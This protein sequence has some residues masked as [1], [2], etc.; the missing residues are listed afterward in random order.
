MIDALRRRVQMMLARGVV[1]LADDSTQAQS[2]QIDLLA[3]ETHEG[4]ERFCDYGFSSV[5]LAGAEAIVAFVGGLRSHG[6]AIKVE[7]RRYRPRDL[8][9]GE[10]TLYDDQGQRV[11]LTRDGLL[12]VSAQKVTLSAPNVTIEA[13]RIELGGGSG[14]AVARVGDE[15]VNGKIV[16]GSDKVSAA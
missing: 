7:D 8:E 12:I 13:D 15:V 6:I 3:D 2:L 14:L 4:V 10:V 1:A 16:S 9:A 11:H 5:P